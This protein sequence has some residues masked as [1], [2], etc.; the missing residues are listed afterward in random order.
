MLYHYASST[1]MNGTMND[2]VGTHVH[3]PEKIPKI[4]NPLSKSQ[5]LGRDPIPEPPICIGGVTVVWQ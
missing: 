4:T 2:E 1:A 3:V 5:S